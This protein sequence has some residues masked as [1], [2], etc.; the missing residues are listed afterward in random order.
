MSDRGGKTP[1]GAAD[2]PAA[3]GGGRKPL[4]T[5]GLIPFP[6]LFREAGF[7][8]LVGLVFLFRLVL[9]AAMRGG[10]RRPE[11]EPL[12]SGRLFGWVLH[13]FPLSS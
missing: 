1:P 13:V 8:G 12:R 9:R 5:H 10:L 3:P 2:V 11:L 7:P 4:R 6:P